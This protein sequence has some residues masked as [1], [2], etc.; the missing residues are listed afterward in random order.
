MKCISEILKR[1]EVN[2]IHLGNLII[3]PKKRREEEENPEYRGQNK[4]DPEQSDLST[5]KT[6]LRVAVSCLEHPLRVAGLV[7]A[8]PPAETDLKAKQLC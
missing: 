1:L 4:R 8:V 7:D 2:A 5:T 6:G 3:L